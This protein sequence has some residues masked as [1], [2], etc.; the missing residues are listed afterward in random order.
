MWIK[1]KGEEGF[2]ESSPIPLDW[3]EE[4]MVDIRAV[5]E[6]GIGMTIW[7]HSS[8]RITI[9][10]AGTIAKVDIEFI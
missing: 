7:D 1:L 9:I 3:L 10:S 8:N 2:V 4:V 6:L 5:E